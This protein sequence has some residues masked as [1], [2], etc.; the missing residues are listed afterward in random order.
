[1]KRLL[2]TTLTIVIALTMLFAMTGCSQSSNAN[3]ENGTNA[4]NGKKEHYNRNCTNC[5]TSFAEY[6]KRLN[7]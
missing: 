3:G 6:H 4:N 2:T 1:M 5:G 7:Y